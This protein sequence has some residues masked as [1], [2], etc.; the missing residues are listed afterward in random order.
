MRRRATA[1][2]VLATLAAA[3]V[4]LVGSGP[5]AADDGPGVTPGGGSVTAT[6]TDTGVA[7]GSEPPAGSTGTG[8]GPPATYDVDF[9]EGLAPE[10]GTYEDESG[11]WGATLAEG[12]SG[13]TWGEV[14]QTLTEYNDAQA[15]G[16][17]AAEDTFDLV[18]YVNQAWQ[19]VVQPPPP[20]PLAIDPHDRAVT[21]LAA[22]LTIGGDPNPTSTL[23]N[24]IGPDV[25]ITMSPRYVVSWDDGST[26][27]TTSQGG[28]YPRGDL[29]H[30]YIETGSRTITVAGVLD[31]DV[32]RRWGR[33]PAARA[34]RAH[35]GRSDRAG[36]RVPGGHRPELGPALAV[37]GGL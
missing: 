15:Y 37:A 14:Q 35:S 27:E 26:T 29:T 23:P 10:E 25:V 7:L 28:P 30:T 32:E 16:V 8:N 19:S 21:G 34:G 31:G 33:R 36:R 20:S 6:D 1:W 17:C 22:F 13:S 5:A 3:G 2:T 18:A 11:C 24:P 4:S 9:F 12:D